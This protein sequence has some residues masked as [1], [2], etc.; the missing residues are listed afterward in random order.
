[1]HITIGIW[2]VIGIGLAGFVVGLLGLWGL[3]AMLQSDWFWKDLQPPCKNG[4]PGYLY[5]KKINP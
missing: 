1:M 4:T 2:G 5:D 3:M